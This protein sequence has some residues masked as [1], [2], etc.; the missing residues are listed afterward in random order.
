M[1]GKPAQG[2]LTARVQQAWSSIVGSRF[3]PVLLVVTP[4]R[5]RTGL[6]NPDPRREA[7]SVAGFVESQ[8]ALGDL[9]ARLAGPGAVRD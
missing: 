6:G 3:S 4:A 1:Q 8:P 5:D 9:V 2:G 7:S